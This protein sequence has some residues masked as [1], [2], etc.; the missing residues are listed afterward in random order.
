MAPTLAARSPI[1]V[2]FG[3]LDCR[4]LQLSEGR[5]GHAVSACE[6]VAATGRTRQT[7]VAETLAPRLKTLGFHGRDCAIGLSSQE[8][9]MT[10]IP[11]DGDHRARRAAILQ[12]AAARA[13]QDEEGVE[14]RCL[15]VHDEADAEGDAGREEYLVFAVGAADKRRSLTAVEALKWRAIGMEASPFPLV[16]ALTPAGAA[17]DGAW[18]VLHLGFGH[19]FFAIVGGSEIRFLK[20]MHLTGEKLLATLHSALQDEPAG[21][22]DAAQLARLLNSGGADRVSE[23]QVGPAALPDVQ[24]LA[25]GRAQAVLDALKLETEAFAGEVRACMRH[26]AN[27]HSGVRLETLRLSGFGA[28]LPELEAVIGGALAVETRVAR[29]FT[30]RGIRAPEVVLAEEHLWT[31]PLGLALRSSMA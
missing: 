2:H 21:G 17:A 9:A 29:P 22:R 14:Y 26:F 15:A 10:Q 12:D 4:L 1:A 6:T 5:R 13:V 20:Q 25:V 31:I 27:R 18:G 8:V 3:A 16:R 23:R 30:E 28:G 19:S 11:I 24:R 7:A